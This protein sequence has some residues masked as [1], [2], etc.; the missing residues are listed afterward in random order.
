MAKETGLGAGFYIDGV[1]LSG[2]MAALTRISKAMSPLPMTGINK[3]AHERKS[4]K[5]TAQIQ[6]QSWFNPDGS[7][8][9]LSDIP[10]TNRV[11]SYVHKV[12]SI[13]TP[14][15]STTG[16][17]VTFTGNRADD[18]GY[19]LAIDILSDAS[20]LDWG[21]AL[22]AGTRTDTTATNGTGV[23]FTAGASF[24]LQAYLHVFAFTGTDCTIA[25]QGSSDNAVG[26]P[27]AAITGGAF[28]Q[29]T[30]APIAE[31]IETARD[32]A[33]ER[34]IRVVT[35]GTFSSIEFAVSVTVN[36]T[37]MVI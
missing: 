8:P 7:H 3:Y 14:V 28:T 27:Y 18:G 2:D 36:R 13:G 25:L 30:S 12:A 20:W 4:G 22:T 29:V 21:L 26:D 1:D 23:D 6:G 9:S 10:R 17:Q 24:G 11:G 31:K 19:V 34:W 16:K 15:A 32:Q 37:S 5:L 33:I 35:T